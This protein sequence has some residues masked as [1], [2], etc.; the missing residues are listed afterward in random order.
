MRCERSDR[1]ALGA[2][3]P[4]YDYIEVYPSGTN[5]TKTPKHIALPL[6]KVNTNTMT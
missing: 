3:V 6:V 2:N 1:L 4:N 5:P